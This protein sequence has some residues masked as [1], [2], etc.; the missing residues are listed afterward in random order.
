MVKKRGLG[1]DLNSLLGDLNTEVS[2]AELDTTLRA[3]K[4]EL[5]RLPIEQLR[6]GQFQPRK[7]M[8]PEGLEELA[9][10]IRT[11]GIIQPI[12]VR[13]IDDSNYEIIAG[14]RRWRAAQLAG[15]NEVP[16]LVRHVGD[17]T[18]V[19]L[20]L[21][22]NI[23]REDLNPIEEAVALHRLLE[24][25]N[26]THQEVAES[27]GKSR[28]AVTNILRLLKLAPQVKTLLEHGDLEM[29]HARA[30]LALMDYESQHHIAQ[31]VVS[32]ELSVRETEKLVKKFLTKGDVAKVTPTIDPDVQLLQ[33]EL[34]T[35]L[36]AKV[37]ITYNKKGKGKL[38]I[39]YYSL[40]ELEGIL[41]HIR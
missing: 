32:K 31:M 36:G 23:Q 20:A 14:E 30:L 12:V 13:P 41:E 28:S 29:G 5:R 18:A 21:I 27:V 34:A 2:V 39:H 15:L 16:A 1:R 33:T 22:E 7:D 26:M 9:G 25:F 17:E 19:A 8:N 10:S 4:S 3:P 35:K 37:S 38:V 6:Q 11:Q 24:E 40:D